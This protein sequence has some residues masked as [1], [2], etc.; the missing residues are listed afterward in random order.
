MKKFPIVFEDDKSWNVLDATLVVRT[1]TKVGCVHTPQSN[2]QIAMYYVRKSKILLALTLNRSLLLVVGILLKCT[3][4]NIK[5][6]RSFSECGK[7]GACTHLRE[8]LGQLLQ[9]LH[10]FGAVLA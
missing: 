2:L 5:N 6:E 3:T 8:P 9:Q 4:C 1:A 10:G 7:L